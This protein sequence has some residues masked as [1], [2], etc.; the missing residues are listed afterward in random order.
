MMPIMMAVFA[1][2]YTSAFSIYIILSTV[3][4]MLTTFGI[5][6]IVDRKYKK[7]KEN[8]ENSVIRGRVYTPKEEEK[9]EKKT[10]KGNE[11]EKADF[12][13]GTADKKKHIR[14]RIK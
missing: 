8:T 10:K 1:F 14:G 3:I 4:S 2:M 9:E 11:E 7:Q 13:S 6:F 5:N 12:L